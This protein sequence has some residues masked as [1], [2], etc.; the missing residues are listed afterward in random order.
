MSHEKV[1]EPSSRVVTSLPGEV[2]D[3]QI[4]RELTGSGVPGQ[5]RARSGLAVGGGTVTLRSLA[6]DAWKPDILPGGEV[7]IDARADVDEPS[8]RVFTGKSLSVSAGS[9]LAPILSLE[10][11]DNIPRRRKFVWTGDVLRPD[12]V[13]PPVKDDVAGMI[14]A[15]ARA[16]G[17]Y[18]TP[19]RT[20]TTL[21]SVSMQGTVIPDVGTRYS[22]HPLGWELE[23]PE[24]PDFTEEDG[25]ICFRKAYTFYPSRGYEEGTLTFL[26]IG[27]GSF[28]VG[29]DF[30]P[31]PFDGMSVFRFNGIVYSISGLSTD[32]C[33][34]EVRHQKIVSG[35]R[36]QLR[37]RDWP[38]GD[39][40]AWTPWLQ[41][42]LPNPNDWPFR[43][44]GVSGSTGSGVSFLTIREGLTGDGDFIPNARMTLSGIEA[45][46]QLPMGA[47]DAWEYIQ[48]AASEVMGAAGLDEN[49]DFFFIGK[50]Q[51][52]GVDNPS[53]EQIGIDGLT[54][55][56]WSITSDDVADRVEVTYNP[57]EETTTTNYSQTVWEATEVIQ[58][59]GGATR[60]ITADFE[61]V[62]AAQFAVW[63]L[64]P[65]FTATTGSRWHTYRT[66]TGPDSGPPGIMDLQFTTEQITPS[67]VRIR[68]TNRT[69]QT[70]WIRTE[71]GG[72]YLILRANYTARRG[73]QQVVEIGASET[74]AQTPF[75]H[76]GGTSIQTYED[77]S[78]LAAWLHAVLAQPL[79]V[80]D[81]VQVA[82][83]PA[84]RI[85][86]VVTIYDPLFT[87][88]R[89]RALIAG[90]SQSGQAAPYTQTVTLALLAVT[91]HD[92]AISF[93]KINPA[94]TISQRAAWLQTQLGPT[95]TLTDAAVWLEK[96]SIE[97]TS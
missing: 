37:A 66:A 39:W 20:S 87:G 69:S 44:V 8:S 72:P 68:I 12:R 55:L 27:D 85:G 16:A 88:I 82:P 34:Y 41:R 73:E 78:S 13:Y 59:N 48:Q 17:F 30:G 31:L 93:Q 14:N 29:L 45:G 24:G 75:R 1:Y 90:I 10:V 57:V 96:N 49:G 32:K 51:L 91:L 36:I 89:A 4:D 42:N 21:L 53:V 9:A 2:I 83:N 97:V 76:D 54:D 28:G 58:I 70:L 74:D 19:P 61:G 84:R 18:T 26:R 71:D 86:Q 52:R 38:T 63:S 80:L 11:Q 46:G 5:A 56:P 94:M 23:F 40:T 60:T 62:A 50:D 47:D 77:A 92:K 15:A 65:D 67:R 35:Y 3:W 22:S 7:T 25:R 79:P 81:S 33:V 64:D 95:A 6:G 43:S